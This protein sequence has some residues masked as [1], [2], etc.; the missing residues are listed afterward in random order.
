MKKAR[1]HFY[2]GTGNTVLVCRNL[3]E[4]LKKS[5]I[6]PESVFVSKGLEPSAGDCGLQIILFPVYA[7]TLPGSMKMYLRRF[8]RAVPGTKAAVIADYGMVSL[9]GGW[10]TGYEGQSLDEAARALRRKGY[11]VFYTGSLGYPIHLTIIADPLPGKL[12]DE[13][14]ASADRDLEK[15]ARSVVNGERKVK[16]YFFL[17]K[18]LGVL[19]GFVFTYI[20]KWH[21]GKLYV[22]DRSCTG[23]GICARYCP[24]HAIRLSGK[25]PRWN[26]RCDACLG[27]FNSCPETA[28]QVSLLR[29]ILITVLT[30]SLIPAVIAWDPV[31]TG[32]ISSLP[33]F[34]PAAGFFTSGWFRVVFGILLYLALY[35]AGFWLA[36]KLVFLLEKIPF[37]APVTEWTYTGKRKRS[38]APGFNPLKDRK[39]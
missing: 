17:D 38:L 4:L 11:D 6:T 15:I 12:M 25:R 33:A 1:I 5:G 26:Y 14:I 27:C 18:W 36:D 21:F 37:L 28:I 7:L 13:I 3:S 32:F 31:L 20:G 35:L 8:P 16:K 29:V 10:H 23:C 24:S 2:S 30:I 9:K 39:L 34:L 19:F 22:A